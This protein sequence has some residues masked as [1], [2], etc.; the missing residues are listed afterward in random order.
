VLAP[1]TVVAVT[2]ER[3]E[4]TIHH[5]PPKQMTNPTHAPHA[6]KTPAPRSA[7]RDVVFEAWLVRYVHPPRWN[8]VRYVWKQGWRAQLTWLLKNVLSRRDDGRARVGIRTVIDRGDELHRAFE[9]LREDGYKITNVLSLRTNHVVHLV[10]RW[11][12]EQLAASTINSR[13][14][15]IRVFCNVIGKSG[16]I[17]DTPRLGLIGIDP[18][19]AARKAVA[20][21]DKSFQGANVDVE[22]VFRRA[23][24][25]DQRFELILRMQD[26]FGLR[27]KEAIMFRPY[28]DDKGTHLE[29][30]HGTKGGRRRDVPVE[31]AAQR[32]LLDRC[33]MVMLSNG[34]S[35]SGTARTLKQ[36]LNWYENLADRIGA[37][38]DGEFQRTLHGLRHGYIHDALEKRGVPVGIK[39]TSDT[40]RAAAIA[41]T[42]EERAARRAARLEVAEAVGHSRISITPAYAGAFIRSGH[43]GESLDQNRPVVADG[44][45]KKSAGAETP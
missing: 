17:P 16:M 12:T 44:A 11:H 38:G 15:K 18:A 42:P 39:L 5:E 45:N 41:K 31:T 22:D 26:A 19:A 32:A 36:A 7:Q 8:E 2:V 9:Q 21:E 29:L 28:A 43:S 37:T 4:R 3:N 1:D 30:R 14:S 20:T 34:D 25:S 33:K 24:R 13:L 10:K 27:K 40:E 6:R 23:E 35:L